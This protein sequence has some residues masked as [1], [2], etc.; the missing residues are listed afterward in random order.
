MTTL[1]STDAA[2]TRHRPM[3]TTTT[4]TPGQRALLLGWAAAFT[5]VKGLA[6]VVVLA[7]MLARLDRFIPRKPA[8][9]ASNASM[10]SME[11]M[12]LAAIADLRAAASAPVAPMIHPW[13]IAHQETAQYSMKG[14]RS[15]ARVHGCSD[16]RKATRAQLLASFYAIA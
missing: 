7:L 11:S 15:M 4:T 2:F 1:H 3:T 9:P 16:W 8:T 14:L 5:L 12:A 13:A 10:E 6:W